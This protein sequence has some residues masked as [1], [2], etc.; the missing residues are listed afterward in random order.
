MRR[1]SIFPDAKPQPMSPGAPLGI[2][3]IFASQA[4]IIGDFSRAPKSR[5]SRRMRWWLSLRQ[6]S[7]LRKTAPGEFRSLTACCSVPV[8]EFVENKAGEKIRTGSPGKISIGRYE[9]KSEAG[10]HQYGYKWTKHCASPMLCFVCAPKIR[11]ERGRDIEQAILVMIEKGYTP[12]FV[13]YTVPHDPTTDPQ[14]QVKRFRAAQ[15][16][17]KSG[18]RWQNFKIKFGYQ[19]YIS[20]TELTDDNPDV[21][22]KTGCHFHNHSVY[23]LK[24]EDEKKDIVEIE[25]FLKD[26]W[27]DAITKEGIEIKKEMAARLH[28]CV[29]EPVRPYYSTTPAKIAAYTAKAAACELSPGILTKKGRSPDRWTHWDV[30][31]AA[32]T[33]RPELAPRAVAIMRALKGKHWLDFSR[34]L[35]EFCGLRKVKDEEFFKTEEQIK[36][37][38]TFGEDGCDWREIDRYR[39]QEQLLDQFDKSEEVGKRAIEII[40]EGV[41]PETGEALEDSRSVSNFLAL[42]R[43]REAQIQNVTHFLVFSQKDARGSPP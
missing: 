6:R 24:I 8:P 9:K 42:E 25:K 2:L 29:V 38:Y 13:T 14:D 40:A 41:D 12:V 32:A 17:L 36:D 35:V 33:T 5:L 19:H 3:P 39:M 23:F 37:V 27:M 11:Y 22:K 28:S 20:A 1:V 7:M 18:R 31:V 16:R 34:G 4:E 10:G 30:I 26:S 21:Y 15:R 43:F